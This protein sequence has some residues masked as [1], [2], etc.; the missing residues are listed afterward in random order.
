MLAESCQK[1]CTDFGIRKSLTL[2][3]YFRYQQSWQAY[4]I[5]MIALWAISKCKTI[6]NAHWDQVCI[7]LL[8]TEN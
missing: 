1:A 5:L 7:L 4:M 6:G 8:I 3:K 2:K